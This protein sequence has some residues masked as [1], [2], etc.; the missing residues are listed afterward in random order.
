MDKLLTLYPQD[1]TQGSP[2]D[3]GTK[4]AFTPEFKRIASI[5]GDLAFQA[6]RRFFL[7][8]VSGKQNTWS[9]CTLHVLTPAGPC[10]PHSHVDSHT[11]SKRQ[12]SVPILGSFHSSDLLNIYGG[13][14]LTDFLIQFV[15]HLNPNGVFGPHW[16]LYTRLSPQLMTLLDNQVTNRTVT[17]DTYRVEGMEFITDLSLAFF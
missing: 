2:Y 11:V 10:L 5:L 14:D 6:P 4:N 8:H 17:L 13:G 16:P 3:T 7:N 12:K 15:T 9:F 1:V